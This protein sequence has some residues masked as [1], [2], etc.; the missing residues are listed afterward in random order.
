MEYVTTYGWAV[1]V[2]LVVGVVIW[3]MGLLDFESRV[4]PGYSGF[5]VLVPEDF[6]MAYAGGSCLLSL[7]M[8]NRAGETLSGLS[9]GGGNCPAGELL[10]GDYKICTKP[11]PGCGSPGSAFRQ[12]VTIVYHRESDNQTF[13][14]SGT[15]WGNIEGN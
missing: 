4:N 15:L 8:G 12:G 13:Q 5:S 14:T 3:Q 6:E 1:L 11:V 9:L 10:P 2:V 7:Q